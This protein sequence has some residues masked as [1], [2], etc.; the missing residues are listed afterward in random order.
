VS[1]EEFGCFLDYRNGRGRERN[2]PRSRGTR[3]VGGAPTGGVKFILILQTTNKNGKPC[4]LIFILFY[5][6]DIG[7]LLANR[8]VVRGAERSCAGNG[9]PSRRSFLAT[10][11]SGLTLKRLLLLLQLL[12][13]ECC[14]DRGEACGYRVLTKHTLHRLRT[15][16]RRIELVV[17]DRFR[18]RGHLFT[19]A[20]CDASPEM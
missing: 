12:V 10:A 20:M 1:A 14:H 5:L 8:L 4:R 19:N 15:H 9:C 16:N 3:I 2:S 13:C 6:F 7:G 11:C 18:L 17:L